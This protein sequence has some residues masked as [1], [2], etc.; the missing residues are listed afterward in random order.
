[1]NQVTKVLPDDLSDITLPQPEPFVPYATMFKLDLPG[2]SSRNFVYCLSCKTRFSLND[3][4]DGELNDDQCP[5]CGRWALD[6]WKTT[7]TRKVPSK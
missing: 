4:I 6:Y 2:E 5:T 7:V 3:L 1:L